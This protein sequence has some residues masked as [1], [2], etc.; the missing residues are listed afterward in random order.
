MAKVKA[1][2]A[3]RP[4][5]EKVKDVIALPYDVMNVREAREMA[6]GNPYSFL[7]IS[8]SEI[9]LEEMEDVHT[10]EVYL[11]AKENLDRFVEEG[12]LLEENK[13]CLYIYRQVMNGNV[14]TGVVACISVDDYIDN[15]VKKHEL[16]RVEK[17]EDRTNHFDIVDAQTEPIFLTYKD[18]NN[19]KTIIN[20]YAEKN[21][22]V[23]DLLLDDGISHTLWVLE[24]DEIIKEITT[25]FEKNDLYIADGH[26][27][28]A[29]AYNVCVKRRK[30]NEAISN[31][32][33]NYNYF[34]AAIFPDSDLKIFDYNR[35]V[36][37]LN[38]FTTEEFLTKIKAA[39]FE[40]EEV[41]EPYRPQKKAEFGMLL[42]EKWYRLIAKAEIIP[43]NPVDSLDVSVLQDNL[44]NPILGIID[45]RTDSRIDFVGGIR[46]LEGL[47]NRVNSDMKIAFST[48]AVDIKDLIEVSDSGMIMPP[49]STWFEPKMGSGLFIHKLNK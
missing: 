46:G 16:T 35:V 13:E 4:N 23:Y 7:H 19:I 44:L 28:T 12:T 27:R 47:V 24:D 2:R 3:I 42:D 33:E 17:E 18:N 45:P 9:D 36:K 20:G 34:M 11:K 5:E 40:I 6:E 38:G 29:S 39:G 30:E 14:Q 49:K 31:G 10:K 41:S 43:N 32:D 48:Y 26:H 1:F 25:L 21:K 37:D 8:R 22:P 15:V